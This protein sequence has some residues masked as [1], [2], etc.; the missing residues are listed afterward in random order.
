MTAQTNDNRYSV[1]NWIVDTNGLSTGASHTT[2][3]AA[4]ASASAN[5][6]ICVRPGTYTEDF[7]VDKS[8]K[9]TTGQ[10]GLHAGSVIVVGTVTQT[11]TASS[12]FDGFQF[13]TNSATIIS[14]TDTNVSVLQFVNCQFVLSDG[15][16]VT[17]DNANATIIFDLCQFNKTADTLDLY[18]ATACAGI[19]FNYCQAFSSSASGVSLVS[20]GQINLR[21][22][23]F[24]HENF[25]TSDTGTMIIEFCELGNGNDQ[26]CLTTAGTGSTNRIVG[27]SFASGTAASIS[28][29]S[30]TTVS[31]RGLVVESTNAA[32]VTGAGTVN[33]G[34]IGFSNTGDTVD[35]TTQNARNMVAGGI[36]FDG[37]TDFL[38]F[39]EEGTWTPTIIGSSTAG[40]ATYVSQTG[41]YKRINDLLFYSFRIS[42]NTGTGTGNLRIGGLPYASH[43]TSFGERGNF[44]ADAGLTSILAGTDQVSTGPVASSTQI[45]VNRWTYGTA[46]A[47]VAYDS[48][49]IV[50]G[51]G[52]HL[53]A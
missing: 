50:F 35:T 8:L 23:N 45:E 25:V 46:F 29:G 12:S 34:P 39:F 15:D 18:N 33:Y 22:S 32:P 42:Y 7:T 17:V 14:M 2:I 28:V 11:A 30:G 38:S 47:S 53:L 41:W 26:I 16:C 31:I 5:Q 36:A 21:H 6:T 37:G 20:A 13:N 44:C 9:F 3:T 27:C 51:S 49:A 40:T 1:A 4:I 19:A 48:A 24:S 43:A 10:N 52:F